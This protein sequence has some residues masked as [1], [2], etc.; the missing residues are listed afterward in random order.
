[1]H[2]N[3]IY[4]SVNLYY[5]NKFYTDALPKIGNLSTSIACFTMKNSKTD[6]GIKIAI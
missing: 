3:E 5:V 1:M 6:L 2:E 4:M